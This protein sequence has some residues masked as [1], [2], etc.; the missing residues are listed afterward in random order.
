MFPRQEIKLVKQGRHSSVL[1]WFHPFL[2]NY[3]RGGNQEEAIPVWRGCA[4]HLSDLFSN[5][6][7]STLPTFW[8]SHCRHLTWT[9]SGTFV[10]KCV[11]IFPIIWDGKWLIWFPRSHTHA[12]YLRGAFFSIKGIQSWVWIRASS[13]GSF[14]IS[15][16]SPFLERL[17]WVFG[18]IK[19]TLKSLDKKSDGWWLLKPKWVLNCFGPVQWMIQH[20]EL[21][22]FAWYLG[23]C[24]L[25][26][27]K[28]LSLTPLG[29]ALSHNSRS[30]RP[31]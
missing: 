30:I 13:V 7:S 11:S 21:Y 2:T 20:Q 23:D 17:L 27:P 24:S 8:L 22:C 5:V 16:T 15:L 1:Q 3:F 14:A 28:S 25:Y 19:T 6:S 9:A 12:L 26:T 10:P 4:W 29:T 31:N 18:H